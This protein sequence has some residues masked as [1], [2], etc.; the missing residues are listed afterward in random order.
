MVTAW[1]FIPHKTVINKF[2]KHRILVA[3]LLIY[4]G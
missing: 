3:K 1:L 4:T 2:K